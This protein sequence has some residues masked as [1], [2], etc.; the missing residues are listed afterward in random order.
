MGHFCGV[1]GLGMGAILGILSGLTKSAEPPSTVDEIFHDLMYR[2]PRN[3]CRK[4]HMR[5]GRICI[6]IVQH[7]GVRVRIESY[8]LG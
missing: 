3:C 2:N 8:S 1:V 7:G 5:S 6:S 4:L